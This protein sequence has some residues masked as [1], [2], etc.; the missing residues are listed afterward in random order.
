MAT[1]AKCKKL[2]AKSVALKQT[3]PSEE[4]GKTDKEI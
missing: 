4:D 3:V 2:T 1:Q